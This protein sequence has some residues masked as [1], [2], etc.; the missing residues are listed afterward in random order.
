MQ[1]FSN[2]LSSQQ[3][4]LRQSTKDI[5]GAKAEKDLVA[6]IDSIGASKPP[7]CI[8]VSCLKTTLLA[9]HSRPT[10]ISI[11][12]IPWPN[13][14]LRTIRLLRPIQRMHQRAKVQCTVPGLPRPVA[15]A[16]RARTSKIFGAHGTRIRT[17]LVQIK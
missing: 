1:F 3:E 17:A 16:V 11:Y 14:S 2:V 6:Y 12:Q 10:L 15:R 7:Q 8:G 5:N 4:T 9:T 13:H